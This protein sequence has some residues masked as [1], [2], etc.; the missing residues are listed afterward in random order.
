MAQGFVSN[1]PT[2]ATLDFGCGKCRS[3]NPSTWDNYDP[4][5]EPDGVPE[6]KRYNVILCTYVLCVLP[7]AERKKV[8]KKIRFLLSEHGWAYITVRNDKPR[9]GW[10]TSKRG[11]YQGR[12]QKLDLPLVHKTSQYRI[13]LLTKKPKLV[14]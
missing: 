13:Y 10:G 1:H 4:H 14:E 9:W 5:Y 12:V 11:T 2:I 3:V 6:G 8:L 7:E